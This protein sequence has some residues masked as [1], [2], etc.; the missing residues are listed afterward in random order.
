MSTT[1]AKPEPADKVEPLDRK[2][3]APSN[4][5]QQEGQWRVF[6]HHRVGPGVTQDTIR[7]PDYWAAVAKKLHRHDI[8]VI[9][10]NDE[11]WEVE[12]CVERVLFSGAHIS[13]RKVYKRQS[14]SDGGT[15]LGNGEFFTEWRPA[16]GWC[17]VRRS[18]NVPVDQGY[19]LEELAIAAWQKRQPR[20]VA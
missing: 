1:P 14:M 11:S 5:L 7:H 20:K 2:L 19:A 8:I 9:L 18:D 13:V 16:G 6:H 17:V 10:A 15:V 12:A 3:R 4:S